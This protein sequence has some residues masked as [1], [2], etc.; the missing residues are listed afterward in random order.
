MALLSNS[1]STAPNGEAAVLKPERAWEVYVV[2]GAHFD[3]GWC[4]SIAETLAYGADLLRRVIDE[5]TG[6]HPDYRFTVEYALFLKYF[7]RLYPDYRERVLRLLDEGKIEVCSTMTGAMEQILDGETTLRVVANA[8]RWARRELGRTLPTAQHS[9]LPGH[10]IQLP[11]ILAKSGVRYLAYSRF[12]PPHGLHWWQAPDGSRVLAAHHT[13]GSYGWAF[14]LLRPEAAQRIAGQLRALESSGTWPAT[15]DLLLMTGQADLV[16]LEPA[17]VEAA[18]A[19]T[20]EGVAR[21]RIATLTQFFDAVAA[22]GPPLPA[23]QGEAPYGFYSLPA[24]E[25]DTYKAAR[26]AEHHLAAAET[27]SSLRDLLGLGRYPHDQLA[28][29]WE[30]LFYPQDHNVGGRHGELNRASREARAQWAGTVGR[31]VVEECLA[32]FATHIRYPDQEGAWSRDP[33]ARRAGWTFPAIRTARGVPVVVANPLAWPRTDV[34]QTRMEFGT[35][36]VGAVRVVDDTGQEVPSQVLSTE[37]AGRDRPALYGAQRASA[38]VLFVARDVP[39][40]GYGTYYLEALPVPAGLAGATETLPVQNDLTVETATYRAQI[41]GGRL[42]GLAERGTGRELVGS[43]VAGPAGTG[44]HRFG[45]VVVLED[46]LVDL[47]DGPIEQ[48]RKVA[49]EIDRPAGFVERPVPPNFTGREWTSAAHPAHVVRIERGPVRTQVVLAGQVLDCPVEHTLTLYEHLP[50]AELTLALDWK[51]KKNALVRAAYPLAVPRAT[52]TYE[53]P[54]GSVVHGRDEMPNSYRGEG[55][56]FV[57]K[58]VDLS[59]GD[60]LRQAQ[61]RL[62]AGSSAGS[63]QAGWGVTWSSRLCAHTLH[64]G[65]EGHGTGLSPLLLRTAYSCGTPFLWYTLEGRHTF[66]FALQAHQGTWRDSHSWRMGWE[67]HFPLLAGRLATARPLAPLPGRDTL[68]QRLSFCTLDGAH[69]TVGT[70]HQPEPETPPGTYAVRLV[71]VEGKGGSASLRFCRP[72]LRAERTNLVGDD[73]E[74]LSV[75]GDRVVVELRPYEIATIQ[76]SLAADE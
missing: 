40:C 42:V 3:L 15:T 66:Q 28:P 55:T 36:T 13:T 48:T 74:P 72:V 10:T 14:T 56:R 25:P 45:E 29:A 73:P 67:F 58:W 46:L 33:A 60:P 71:E 41:T 64:V 57:Q 39:A 63:G 75:D 23:Y 2:P 34:V 43:G 8:Q 47:E 19:L 35:A 62:R 1:A 65:V 5:I 18:A 16:M 6:P 70:I 17:V 38:D 4:A 21:F 68:P 20:R 11:Q 59:A 49:P 50:R 32:S 54:Y 7:L 69:A 37:E 12:R 9:D 51:G 76:V 52:T 61:G 24:W 27:F 44:P 22:A 53:T 31:E 26:V 30:G